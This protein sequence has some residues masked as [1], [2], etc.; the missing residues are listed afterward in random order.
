MDDTSGVRHVE[1]IGDLNSE[2]E[3]FLNS[4]RLAV[5]VFTQGFAVDELHGDER[6][7][8]LLANVVDGADARV[9]QSGSGVGFTAEALQS[10][11]VL[12][13]AVGKKFQGDGTVEPGVQGLV[14]DTHSAST[15]FL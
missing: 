13:H 5:D 4:E 3:D 2:V 10:L 15:E 7:M 1:G 6:H 14:D 12:D 9:V 8:I 11:G